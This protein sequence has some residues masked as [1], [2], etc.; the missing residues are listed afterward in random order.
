MLSQ[1]S[2][3]KLFLQ[4]KYGFISALVKCKKVSSFHFGEFDSF[5]SL[6]D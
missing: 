5:I 4:S 2:L 6:F 3:I 1:V